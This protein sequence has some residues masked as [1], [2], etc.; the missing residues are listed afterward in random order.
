MNGLEKTLGILS[1]GIVLGS[2][3]L[4]GNAHASGA[5]STPVVTTAA[6]GDSTYCS[7]INVGKTPMT[8]ITVSL[9]DTTGPTVLATNTCLAVR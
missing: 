6:P 2:F 9:I 8:S 1:I 4:I 5:L 3:G 7:G